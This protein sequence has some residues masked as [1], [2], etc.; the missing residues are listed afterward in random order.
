MQQPSTGE[1]ASCC[2]C[3]WTSVAWACSCARFKTCAFLTARWPQVFPPSFV[4]SCPE[5]VKLL[6]TG[7]HNSK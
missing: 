2:L 5:H 7:A 6:Y 4:A 1:P 3:A